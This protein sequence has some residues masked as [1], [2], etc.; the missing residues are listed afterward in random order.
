[1]KS[2]ALK[3]TVL[4]I[5]GIFILLFLVTTFPRSS[6]ARR[7]AE[8]EKFTTAEIERGWELA[9]QRNLIYWTGVFVTLGFYTWLVF[10]GRARRLTGW[11][12]RRSG[13]RWPLTLIFIAAFCFFANK[14]LHLPL[15]IIGLENWR[16]WRMT[17]LS[18]AD[19]LGDYGKSTL[20]SAGIGLVLLLGLYAL[21]RWF[22]RRWWLIAAGLGSLAG[23]AFAFIMPLWI[24][25][26]FYNFWPLE[27][28]NPKL[29][30][31]LEDLAER[32]GVPVQEVLVMDASRRG[33]HTNAYFTGFGSSRRIIL[34]DT[35]L[36]NHPDDEVESIMA[37]EIGH[38]THHHITKGLILAAVGGLVGFFLLSL[39]LRWAVQRPPFWL[40]S[41][42][43]PA[44]WPLIMLLIFLSSW[45]VSPVQNAVS[46]YFERQADM[47]SLQL[48]GN[49]KVF[50]KA[51]RRLARENKSNVAPSPWSV[52]LFS[53]HPPTVDRIQMARE[54]EKEKGKEN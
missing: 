40:K 22:P 54:W 26:L 19:W 4:A 8:R 13:S 9:T 33:N 42:A 15:R 12:D 35:L 11:F 53:T 23:V 47:T 28:E 1:M 2:I 43:D 32:A 46:R 7:R 16:A 21:M 31:K 25:P 45:L 44:G 24:D 18:I 48:A 38:W 52:W 49:P 29:A 37:H 36:K 39:I 5:F 20:L 27:E 51:E 3:V 50:I 30:R 41:P 10:S 14:L 34:Y 6:E 17:N